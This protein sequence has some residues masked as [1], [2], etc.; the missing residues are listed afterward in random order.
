M[1]PPV[2]ENEEGATFCL[3]FLLHLRNRFHEHST[4][5]KIIQASE[6][7]I[8]NLQTCTSPQ[9]LY[10]RS[11]A[12][13]LSKEL[14]RQLRTALCAAWWQLQAW[15]LERL[16][17]YLPEGTKSKGKNGTKVGQTVSLPTPQC[18]FLHEPIREVS[19]WGVWVRGIV[20]SVLASLSPVNRGNGNCLLWVVATRTGFAALSS[21]M[22]LFHALSVVSKS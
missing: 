19:V 8:P 18:V 2:C 3:A 13:H 15:W 10:K 9:Y 21:A 12:P 20:Q 14:H 5:Y 22:W 11:E 6:E 1:L 7:Q 4:T 17:G 16:W